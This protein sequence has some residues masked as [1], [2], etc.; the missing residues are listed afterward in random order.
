ME[1]EGQGFPGP[2]PPAPDPVTVQAPDLNMARYFEP[3]QSIPVWVRLAFADG[4]VEVLKG[5]AK[6]WTRAHVKVQVQIH[7]G[8]DYYKAA[9][10]IW[11]E[12][13]QVRRRKLQQDRRKRPRPLTHERP[14]P[15]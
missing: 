1:R 10:D 11:V 15:S 2:Q 5:F 8:D 14:P 6:G 13:E 4:T 3:K 12:P 7:S 9:R